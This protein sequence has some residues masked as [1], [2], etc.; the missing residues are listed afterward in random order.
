MTELLKK[1]INKLIILSLIIPAIGIIVSYYHGFN[2]LFND[3]SDLGVFSQFFNGGVIFG[4]IILGIFTLNNLT[5]ECAGFSARFFML[6]SATCLI[7]IGIYKKNG[8]YPL[9]WSIAAIC[10]LSISIAWL[11]IGKKLIRYYPS[12]GY[13]TILAALISYSTWFSY[14]IIW[15]ADHR[16]GYCVPEVITIIT[17]VTWILVFISKYSDKKQIN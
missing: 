15:L 11:L 17:I 2:W 6:L 7:L 1:R 14:F 10:L 8:N 12:M 9:H 16:F 13:F 4:G 3:L 5:Q